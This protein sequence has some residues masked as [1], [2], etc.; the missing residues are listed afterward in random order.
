MLGIAS[1]VVPRV[2]RKAYHVIADRRLP[3]D[4]AR[5]QRAN[6]SADAPL[7]GD[8]PADVSMTT[9]GTRIRSV[10]LALES[11]GRGDLKPRR[12]IL[13]LDDAD[14]FANLPAPLRRLQQR[15]LEVRLTENYGPHTKYWPYVSG[16]LGA[17]GTSILVTADDD[18]IA[19]KYWLRTLLERARPSVMTAFRAHRVGVEAD[20][21]FAPYNDW[22]ECWAKEASYANFPTGVSGLAYPPEMQDALRAAGTD[23]VDRTPRADDVWLHHIGVQAGIPTQ[24][25][26]RWPLEFPLAPESQKVGLYLSNVGQSRNDDQIAATYSPESRQRILDALAAKA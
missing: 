2:T 6:E 12:I 5:L 19:P 7:L 16:D 15:G 3:A 4:L 8:A 11:I 26:F 17:G 13:W 14:A 23:F 24:Q 21:S 22:E 1:P 10:H 9:H 25:V 20:G 18:V